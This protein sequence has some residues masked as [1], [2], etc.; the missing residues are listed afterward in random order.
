MK[1]ATARVALRVC[2][3][4]YFPFAGGLPGKIGN[5]IS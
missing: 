1:N 3:F 4:D 2:S 5:G